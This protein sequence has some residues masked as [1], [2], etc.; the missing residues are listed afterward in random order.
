M[1]TEKNINRNNKNNNLQLAIYRVHTTRTREEQQ[2]NDYH[3]NRDTNDKANNNP[4]ENQ[5]NNNFIVRAKGN[6]GGVTFTIK[7][8]DIIG[9]KQ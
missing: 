7:K 9:Q 3:D 5:S 8:H 4:D 6:A 2:I 1:A